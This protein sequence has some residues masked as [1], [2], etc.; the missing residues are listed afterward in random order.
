M[1]HWTRQAPRFLK[2]HGL[3]PEKTALR[4]AGGIEELMNGL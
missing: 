3:W 4:D 2:R 1:V